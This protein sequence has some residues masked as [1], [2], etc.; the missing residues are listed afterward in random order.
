[1]MPLLVH[2]EMRPC[3][4][5][6]THDQRAEVPRSTPLP[7]DALLLPWGRTRS[8]GA[9]GRAGCERPLLRPQSKAAAPK[10][11]PAPAA[12]FCWG[13]L[14]AG[15]TPD[16]ARAAGSGQWGAGCCGRVSP[17]SSRALRGGS[18]VPG[19]AHGESAGETS[20][21]MNCS[22]EHLGG[23]QSPLGKPP[24]APDWPAA[25]PT[26]RGEGAAGEEPSP[27]SQSTVKHLIVPVPTIS[28][29]WIYALRGHL[30]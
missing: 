25:F 12:R 21:V 15:Q 5:L 10:H 19:L 27:A 18:H 6:D 24:G 2:L 26:A 13:T 20:Q 17:W 30:W 4:N 3:L 9:R 14:A 22:A 16:A 28:L 7:W 1:M 29:A 8:P 11:R 23:C